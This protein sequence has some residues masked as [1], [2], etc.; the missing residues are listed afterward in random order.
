[1]RPCPGAALAALEALVHAWPLAE[2]A[3]VLVDHGALTTDD[4][5][6]LAGVIAD[7]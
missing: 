3:R 5:E 6:R 4:L 2:D 7:T 1:M